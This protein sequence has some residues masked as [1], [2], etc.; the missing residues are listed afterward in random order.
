MRSA[1]TCRSSASGPGSSSTN[2][3]ASGVAR[4][5]WPGVAPDRVEER[6]EGLDQPPRMDDQGRG[7]PALAVEGHHG[8]EGVGDDELGG[9]ALDDAHLLLAAQHVDEVLLRLRLQHVPLEDDPVAHPSSGRH[10][11]RLVRLGGDRRRLV[12][13]EDGDLLQR[14][15]AAAGGTAGR[16]RSCRRR[17]PPG[18]GRR[19]RRRCDAPRP[20]G[21]R[22]ARP[23]RARAGA[24]SGGPAAPRPVARPPTARWP[25]PTGPPGRAARVPERPR[26][27]RPP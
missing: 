1:S 13:D 8:R 2:S 27:P 19:W 18:P 20:A 5:E 15:R 3:S 26:W 7:F 11:L 25:P 12:G 9:H 22:P 14:P 16:R 17:S 10:V 24:R 6:D 4:A 23:G 21:R